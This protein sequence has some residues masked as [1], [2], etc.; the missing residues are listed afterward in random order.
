MSV[1]TEEVCSDS[2]FIGEATIT[3]S[4]NNKDLSGSVVFA[5]GEQSGAFQLKLPY[6]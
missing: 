2:S 5:N 6:Y 4:L 3:I 1:V